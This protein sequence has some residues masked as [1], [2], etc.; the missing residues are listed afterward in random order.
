MARAD[1]SYVAPTAHLDDNQVLRRGTKIWHFTH[2]REGAILGEHC[3]IGDFCYIDKG[4]VLGSHCHIANHVSVYN[5]VMLSHHV[6]VG[7]GARFTNDTFRLPWDE[8]DDT[9]PWD[10]QETRVGAYT[11]IGAGSII[12]CGV[13]I[14]RHCVIAAGTIVLADVPDHSTVYGTWKGEPDVS[15]P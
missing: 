13:K 1:E 15:T 9:A 6:L 8:S 2:V 10:F 7:P 11:R 12:R 3:V 5:G 14:G 4:A